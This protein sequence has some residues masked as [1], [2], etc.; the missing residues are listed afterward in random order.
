MEAGGST[1]DLFAGVRIEGNPEADSVTVTVYEESVQAFDGTV[2]Y[3]DY[4]KAWEY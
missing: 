4:Q 1:E 3:E 2:L